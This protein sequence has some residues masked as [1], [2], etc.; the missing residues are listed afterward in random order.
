MT[1]SQWKWTWA[2][3][4]RVHWL[5]SRQPS[6]ATDS[7]GPQFPEQWQITPMSSGKPKPASC[8]A[9]QQTYIKL[10]P[11]R[12]IQCWSTDY[13]TSVFFTSNA[14]RKTF[15]A[16]DHL[17]KT[18][19]SLFAA[20]VS[21]QQLTSRK[22]FVAFIKW[23]QTYYHP[24]LVSAVCEQMTFGTVSVT[25]ETDCWVTVPLSVMAVNGKITFGRSLRLLLL[26]LLLQ[27]L[28]STQ[29]QSCSSQRRWFLSMSCT[30]LFEGNTQQRKY[31]PSVTKA[32]TKHITDWQIMKIYCT[33][34]PPNNCVIQLAL[35][36]YNV[37]LT[38][39]HRS[40]T[41]N[42][43]F[44]YCR[45]TARCITLVNSCY[46]SRGMGVRKVSNSK[47]TLKVIQ[48]MVPFDRQHMISY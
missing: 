48:W 3:H 45:R 24:L 36:S 38:N 23:Y 41:F 27:N 14:C 7:D 20:I 15:Q 37:I 34:P 32:K 13:C 11:Q 39:N 42:K 17:Y 40:A 46:V 25:A 16:I 21:F 18:S 35:S 44:C 2:S 12:A 30:A 1:E 22:Q 10:Q 26:L 29:I 8:E 6:T 33:F 5:Q 19:K 28:Y 43:K 9:G 47:V 4:G 31:G